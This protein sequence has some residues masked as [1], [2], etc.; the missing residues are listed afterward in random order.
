MPGVLLLLLSACSWFAPGQP[1]RPAIAVVVSRV[2]GPGG[3]AGE[4]AVRGVR[5][6]ADDRYDVVELDEAA[7]DVVA[8]ALN[9]PL[10][11]GVIAHTSA[12]AV[13]R[14]GDAWVGSGLAVLTLA[15]GQGSTLPRVVPDTSELS[16]CA[17]PLVVG[18]RLVLAYDGS[19]LGLS[20]AHDLQGALGSRVVDA[21]GVG[22]NTLGEDLGRMAARAPDGLIYVGGLQLGGDLART[23][24]V[25][26]SET[27]LFAV[28]ISATDFADAAGSDAGL[29]LVVSPDRPPLDPQIT[30][31]WRARFGT[32]PPATGRTAYDAARLMAAAMDGAASAKG[33]DRVAPARAAVAAALRTTAVMGGGGLLALGAAGGPVPIQCTGY[34]LENGALTAV[35]VGRVEPDGTATAQRLDAPTVRLP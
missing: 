9:N 25:L 16:R 30:E 21:I 3:R 34:A 10:I 19:D 12:S 27:P 23:R 18:S 4:A 11:V 28:G 32:A 20:A 33:E 2:A 5:L 6:A 1:P 31:A 24:R 22:P 14:L 15:A 26:K 7:P 35:A 8:Q 13:A 29:V 17:V